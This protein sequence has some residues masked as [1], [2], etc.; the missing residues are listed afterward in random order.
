MEHARAR[1]RAQELGVLLFPEERERERDRERGG[2]RRE[3]VSKISLL[4]EGRFSPS[5]LPGGERSHP[6]AA[7]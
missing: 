4:L 7:I 6:E 1:A 3:G 5:P 2:E